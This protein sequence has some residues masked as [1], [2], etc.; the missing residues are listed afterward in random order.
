MFINLLN[1]IHIFEN[2]NIGKQPYK[3]IFR[4]SLNAGFKSEQTLIQYTISS[5]LLAP[6][7]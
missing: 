4:A 3:C 1:S 7:C 5:L 6:S 2:K